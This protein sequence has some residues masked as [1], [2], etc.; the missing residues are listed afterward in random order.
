M[1]RLFETG[2]KF[3]FPFFSYLIT[4]LCLNSKNATKVKKSLTPFDFARINHFQIHVKF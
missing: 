3:K 4:I 1:K 2:K